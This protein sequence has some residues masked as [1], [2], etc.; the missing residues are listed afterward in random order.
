MRTRSIRGQK[1][2]TV[3]RSQVLPHLLSNHGLLSCLIRSQ[4]F[5]IQSGR[6]STGFLLVVGCC[7]VQLC[8]H[9]F[10]WLFSQF[11]WHHDF[12]HAPESTEAQE[13]EWLLVLKG[14]VHLPWQTSIILVPHLVCW[15]PCRCRGSSSCIDVNLLRCTALFPSQPGLFYALC[16]YSTKF[17]L[18]WESKLRS[19]RHFLKMFDFASRI[20]FLFYIGNYGIR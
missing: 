18:C 17:Q 7:S 20:A 14:N 9:L 13:E 12:T 3:S 10:G 1:Q 11:P 2:A 8:F 5:L 16:I 15:A 4:V 6:C 19:Y